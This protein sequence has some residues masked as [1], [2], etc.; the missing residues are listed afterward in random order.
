MRH[1]GAL[2]N[3]GSTVEELA[4]RGHEVHLSFMLHD[5]LEEGQ[6]ML[7]ALQRE[8][9]G[10]SHDRIDK[11]R[12]WRAWTHVARGTRSAADYL[13]YR[14]P[15]FAAARPLRKRAAAEVP[16]PLRSALDLPLMRSSMGVRMAARVLRL[17]EAGIPVDPWIVAL[18]VRERPDVVL[19]TPLVEIGSPQVEYVKA[20]HA[21][22]I[23]V[24]LCVHSWDNLTNKG[25]I[26][27]NP[28]RVFVWNEAQ[29][30]EAVTLHAV[31]AERVVPTGAP[32]YDQ[33]FERAPSVS[34]EAFCRKAGL[35]ADRPFLLYLCSSPFISARESDQVEAW[36]AAV[37]SAPDASV[38]DAGILVRP[39]PGAA[40]RQWDR[41]VESAP[42]HVA[43]W[44]RAGANPVDAESRSDYFDS[45][46]YAAA[47]VGIN[48]SAQIEAAIAG[49][50]VYSMRSGDAVRTQDGTLHFRHLLV[51]GGGLLHM[52][53]TLDDHVRVLADALAQKDACRSKLRSFLATFVRPYGLAH[54][55]TPRLAN[56]IEELARLPK[57][58]PAR[59]P[60]WAP[61]VRAA[62]YPFVMITRPPDK[63]QAARRPVMH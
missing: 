59:L 54:S 63:P 21:L 34:R 37:R 39:H 11:K 38:R 10:I 27:G 62:L 56:A 61:V 45:L 44:P 49:C 1:S 17:A 33:W 6:A 51:E 41:L 48:T 28:D 43:V 40:A 18:M 42:D 32:V 7:A 4:R 47:A 55:A 60:A 9:S 53:E 26:R 31:P 5:K 16:A 30:Q 15:A 35:P 13:R 23:A 20:A 57:P 3:F 2:R 8:H 14:S 19:V 25:L 12:P 29:K 22:G 50:P 58:A 52:S 24:A 36:I 46:H